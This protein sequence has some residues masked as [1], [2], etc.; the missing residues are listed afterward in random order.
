[1]IK[2]TEDNE[3]FVGRI[4][5]EHRDVFE[6]AEA[7][8]RSIENENPDRHFQTEQ[9]LARLCVRLEEHLSHEEFLMQSA[10]YP[11]YGW[12]KQQHDTLRRRIKLFAPLVD[13]GS[14]EAAD[15]FLEFLAGWLQ[16]HTSVADRMMAAYLRNYERAH[17]EVAREMLEMAVGRT[18]MCRPQGL[19]AQEN[20]LPRVV[21]LGKTCGG[22]TTHELRPRGLLA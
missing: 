3:V 13:S 21:R 6:I 19:F 20:P 22:Q 11:S 10:G 17:R 2:W 8:E 4:D 1:V 18:G 5:A 16:D 9:C 12:H 15:A 7:F 14:R